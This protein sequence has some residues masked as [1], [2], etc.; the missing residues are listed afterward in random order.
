MWPGEFLAELK[1]DNHVVVMDEAGIVEANGIIESIDKQRW[2]VKVTRNKILKQM[3]SDI[4]ATGAWEEFEKDKIVDQ[5]DQGSGWQKNTLYQ[6]DFAGFD[7]VSLDMKKANF[8]ALRFVNLEL[9]L[10]ANSYEDL[11]SIYTQRP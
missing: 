5:L 7:Y 8:Q 9:V 11:L 4:M 1:V 2:S 3:K 6:S 10:G